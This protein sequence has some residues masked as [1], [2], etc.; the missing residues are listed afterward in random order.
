MFAADLCIGMFNFG[1]LCGCIYLLAILHV[2][3][4]FG[5]F[6]CWLLLAVGIADF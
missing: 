5:W 4:G 1:Y 3:V 2:A 6:V